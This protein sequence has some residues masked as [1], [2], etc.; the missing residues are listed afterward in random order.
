MVSELDRAAITLVPQGDYLRVYFSEPDAMDDFQWTKMFLIDGCDVLNT[1]HVYYDSRISASYLNLV[2]LDDVPTCDVVI[3][4]DDGGGEITDKARALAARR[5]PVMTFSDFRT[6]IGR[7]I[8][9]SEREQ[10]ERALA[11]GPLGSAHS[12]TQRSLP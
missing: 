11:I 12:L 4:P 10:Y 5:I 6:A 2:P 1:G 8:T 9:E 7:P 3:C